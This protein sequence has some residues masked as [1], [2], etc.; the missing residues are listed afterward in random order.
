MV[1]MITSKTIKN[2]N[3]SRLNYNYYLDSNVDTFSYKNNSFFVNNKKWIGTSST[4]NNK[5]QNSEN[6]NGP[7]PQNNDVENPQNNNNNNPESN[8]NQSTN[9]NNQNLESNSD[10]NTNNNVSNDPRKHLIESTYPE[11]L[12]YAGDKERKLAKNLVDEFDKLKEPYSSDLMDGIK[13]GKLLQKETKDI[14]EHN[15]S[16]RNSGVGQIIEVHGNINANTVACKFENPDG[17]LATEVVSSSTPPDVGNRQD[18]YNDDFQHQWGD[19]GQAG[20][21]G[22]R[23]DN[24][25]ESDQS[26]FSE[27]EGYDDE[28]DYEPGPSNQVTTNPRQ[29][30]EDSDMYGPSISQNVRQQ[31][32]DSDMYGPSVSQNVREP[33]S[34]E[35]METN[36]SSKKK[37]KRKL[38]Q[39]SEENLE[40]NKRPKKKDKDDDDNEGKG[41]GSTTGLSD[42]TGTSDSTRGEDYAGPSNF[43]TSFENALFIV[44]EILTSIIDS[45]NEI[46]ILL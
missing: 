26:V 18:Y 5:D 45:I 12:T 17:S 11:D 35:N 46:L 44:F 36:E 19:E 40:T 3:L 23:S 9:N 30:S 15:R 21:S 13:D 20:P 28:M 41:S 8:S 22:T 7:N 6:N 31:S 4:E 33:D 42:S 38:E 24:Q 34:E 27:D 43:R 25:T 1:I 39:D 16:V 29:Q 32:E 2:N 10:Q 37:G 14:T